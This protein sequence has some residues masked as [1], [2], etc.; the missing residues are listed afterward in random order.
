MCLPFK[1]YYLKNAFNS[2]YFNQKC[3]FTSCHVCLC[4]TFM[5]IGCYVWSNFF[6]IDDYY[7]YDTILLYKTDFSFLSNYRKISD[8]LK[9]EILENVLYQKNDLSSICFDPLHDVVLMDK[10]QRIESKY[11]GKYFGI[12]T[13]LFT[14]CSKEIKFKAMGCSKLFLS[15]VW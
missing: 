10:T 14:L 6:Q 11:K 5:R 3:H 2:G 4:L 9:K 1:R 13:S 15:C 8:L 7:L 12:S